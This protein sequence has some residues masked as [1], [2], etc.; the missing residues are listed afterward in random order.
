MQIQAWFS[1][2][3]F[4]SF[5]LF[6]SVRTLGFAE[7]LLEQPITNQITSQPRPLFGGNFG[8]Q[9]ISALLRAKS[10]E[11][12]G[13]TV[14]LPAGT[15]T[16]NETIYVPQFTSLRGAGGATTILWRLPLGVRISGGSNIQIINNKFGG[17][18]DFLHSGL[19]EGIASI[20]IEKGGILDSSGVYQG[21]R[22]FCCWQ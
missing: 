10:C 17:I 14:Y 5:I 1:T 6:I 2:F 20:L 4:L 9:E 7:L 18:N 11:E 12:R 21:K 13:G 15:Y 19:Q 8:A 16:L 22:L 3:Q